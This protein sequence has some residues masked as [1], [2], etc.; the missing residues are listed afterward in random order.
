MKLELRRDLEAEHHLLGALLVSP[1]CMSD[2]T[3]I[4]RADDFYSPRHVAIWEALVALRD[5]NEVIDSIT[6]ESELSARGQLQAAGGRD[7]LLDLTNR[8]VR[9]ASIE[10]LAKH[11]R[12][13]ST[14]RSHQRRMLGLLAES[15]EPIEDLDR[16][17]DRV[18]SAFA[19]GASRLLDAEPTSFDALMHDVIADM[20]EQSERG[21]TLGY[22][23]GLHAL[24]RVLGGLVPSEMTVLTGRPGMGKTSAALRIAQGVEQSSGLPVLIVSR[25]MRK[26]LLGRRVVSADARIDGNALRAGKLNREQWGALTSSAEQLAKR[27][28]YVVDSRDVRTM[29]D[30]RRMARRVTT[31]EKSPLA[32]IAIDYVGIVEPIERSA[33]REREVAAISADAV[34]LGKDT[35]A[36][37]LLLAQLNRDVEKRQDK[38]PQLS[39]LRESGSLE[40]DAD[41]VIMIYRDE[42]YR[43]DSPDAGIAELLIEKQRSGPTG[44]VRVAFSGAHTSFENLAYEPEGRA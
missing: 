9:S 41:N 8:V 26:G 27:R 25:E 38:R 35:N 32:L 37:I 10:A 12:R 17:A 22:L 31:I 16:F 15:Q 21:G 5:R 11:L 7:A 13:E 4:L 18:E 19:S 43:A 6:L 29:L 39:D 28:I 36:H 23:T 34:Q 3:D 20:V 42:Y 33:N 40:Q 2:A 44:T 30:I 14:V 24:D 1:E